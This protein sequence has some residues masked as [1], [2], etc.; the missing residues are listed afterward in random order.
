MNKAVWVLLLTGISLF[1]TGCGSVR[2]ARK[3]RKLEAAR[4]ADSI[5]TIR[6]A[7]DSLTV[8]IDS[9]RVSLADTVETA[10]LDP[11]RSSVPS[12]ILSLHGRTTSF[13]TFSGKAKMEY[14]SEGKSQEFTA[15]FRIRRDSA[16]WISAAAM[17]GLVPVARI[18]ITPDSFLLVN[19]L[20]REASRMPIAE[21]ARLLPLPARFSQLQALLLGDVLEPTADITSTGKAEGQS[22]YYIA[23]RTPT[24]VYTAY[25]NAVDSTL[26]SEEMVTADRT[27]AT[28][29]LYKSYSTGEA[30]KFA[31]ERE[32]LVDVSDTGE[33]LRH[34][35]R[36]DF[37]DP[38]RFD[39]PLDFSFSIPKNY[40]LK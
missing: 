13:Q 34:T 38:P 18:L 2:K 22:I 24:S 25:Y 9:S 39:A 12:Y 32:V 37:S 11:S 30:R 40:T 20:T 28:N 29:I 16:I 14:E 36:M 26:T 21:A 6:R 27:V 17:G 23:T 1:G 10:A 31:A 3:A 8:R 19:Y 35:L 5:A 33:V 7:T 15:N 4:R